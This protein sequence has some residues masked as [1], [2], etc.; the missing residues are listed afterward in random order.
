MHA[1]FIKKKK[2]IS[3]K[4]PQWTSNAGVFNLRILHSAEC[5]PINKL[6]T[7]SSLIQCV[8]KAKN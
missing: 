1:N 2:S 4:E 7:Q 6:L 3:V 8:F 5:L